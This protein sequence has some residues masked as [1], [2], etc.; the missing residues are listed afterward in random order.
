[1]V[2]QLTCSY[3]LSYA[4][5]LNFDRKIWDSPANKAACLVTIQ[6]TALPE[7]M[8]RVKRGPVSQRRSRHPL[9]QIQPTRVDG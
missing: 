3:K 8:P 4:N 1:M 2:L 7:R 5:N 6:R 9:N